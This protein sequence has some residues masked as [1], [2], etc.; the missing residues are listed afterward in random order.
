MPRI[1]DNIDLP[2]LGAL[3]DTLQV[4]D[5]SDFCVGYFNLRGGQIDNQTALRIKKSLAEH[6]RNQLMMGF[7]TNDHDGMVP[8]DYQAADQAVRQRAIGGE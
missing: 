1:F 3:K 7:P 4:S 5:R 6:F 8:A 2:L